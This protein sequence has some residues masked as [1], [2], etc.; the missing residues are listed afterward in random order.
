MDSIVRASGERGVQTPWRTQYGRERFMSRK[1]AIGK[2]EI[3]RSEYSQKCT[4]KVKSGG[5]YEDQGRATTDHKVGYA[6]WL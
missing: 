2:S 3:E 6:E 1:T 5:M 4:V